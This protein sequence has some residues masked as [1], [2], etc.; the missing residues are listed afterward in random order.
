MSFGFSLQL[1]RAETSGLLS[2]LDFGDNAS[3]SWLRVWT[4]VIPQMQKS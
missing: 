4:Q 1:K 2:A 3:C